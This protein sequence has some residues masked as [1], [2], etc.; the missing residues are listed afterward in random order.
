MSVKI[1]ARVWANS[2]RKD[3]ELLVMLA[4]ADFANDAGESWPSLEVLAQKARLTKRQV[5]KVLDKLQAA[6]EIRRERS[7]G[8]RNR[9]TRYF[10]VLNPTENGEIKTVLKKHCNKNSVFGDTKTVSYSSHALNRHRTVNKREST[11]SDKLIPDSLSPKSKRKPT[12]PDPAQVRAFET[13]YAAY[14]KRV[15]RKPALKAW[16]KLDPDS[17]LVETIMTATARYADLKAG[18]EARFVLDPATWIYQERWTDET[19][20]SNGNGH[21]KP[22]QVKDLG[23]GMIEVDGVQMDRRIYER[24][25]GQR[26][27]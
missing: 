22:A 1:M 9:R 21:A 4:L 23:N 25:H 17:A 12:W 16:L 2:Q 3:G 14:P 5:C 26:A 27:N 24:R 6:G 20:M 8:G 19:P 7:T 15:G 11:E 18:V 13:W 10:I